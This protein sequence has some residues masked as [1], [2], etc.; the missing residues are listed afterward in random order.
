MKTTLCLS[1]LLLFLVPS[2]MAQPARL[3]IRLIDSSAA[4]PSDYIFEIEVKN[5]G[6]SK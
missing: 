6:F 2:L 3:T 4:S 1:A 5:D